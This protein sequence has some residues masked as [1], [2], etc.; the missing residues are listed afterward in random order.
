MNK[1]LGG[2]APWVKSDG[3]SQAVSTRDVSLTKKKY[4]TRTAIWRIRCE[5]HLSFCARLY[6]SV[7]D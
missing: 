3:E 5:K 2:A 6:P 1:D 7:C 4:S